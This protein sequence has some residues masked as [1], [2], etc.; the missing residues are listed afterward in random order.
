MEVVM[1]ENFFSRSSGVF[2]RK[3]KNALRK[4]TRFFIFE[5]F[6]LE[7]RVG[8]MHVAGIDGDVFSESPFFV[9][10][11]ELER[12]GFRFRFRNPMPFRAAIAEHRNA[13]FPA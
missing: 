8:E 6:V 2:L 5:N 10:D 4:E 9:I 7:C 12:D 1:M 3:I 11:E 13:L